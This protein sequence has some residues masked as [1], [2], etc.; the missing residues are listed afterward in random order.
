MSQVESPEISFNQSQIQKILGDHATWS[1]ETNLTLTGIGS[2]ES[3]EASDIAFLANPKYAS[4]LEDCKASLVLVPA[5]FDGA[6]RENQAFAK[7]KHPSLGLAWICG[8][9]EQILLPAPKPGIDPLASVSSDAVVD[10]S[11]CIGPFC[12]VEAGAVVGARVH[13]QSQV[14]VGRGAK[15]GADS[16]LFPHVTLYAYCEIGERCRVHAS[17]AIGSDGF[18]YASVAGVH[19]KEPQIGIVRVEDDVEI[20]ANVAIDRA[21]FDVTLIGRG[22][23]IDNLVQIAHNVQIGPGCIVVS[24]VGISGSTELGKYVVVAGQA[25]LAGHLKV[26]DMA[27]IAA[28]AGINRD[29]EPGAKVRGNPYMEMIQFGRIAVLQ[30]RLPDFFKRLTAL[31]KLIDGKTNKM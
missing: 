9:I 21:R 29:V 25:G 20:G 18:G 1:G 27:V 26:G 6:P 22:A 10:P 19:H 28:K 31:E 2:L 4:Q 3:A 16:K 17:T 23:K 11:A 14:S 30:K 13:L 15:I 12:V 8:A 24:Q 7:M 5:D